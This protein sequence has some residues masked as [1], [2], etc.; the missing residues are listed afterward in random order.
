MSRELTKCNKMLIKKTKKTK[1][2]YTRHIPL[3]IQIDEETVEAEEAAVAGSRRT[4]PT[5]VQQVK[6]PA[7]VARPFPNATR[8]SSRG[9]PP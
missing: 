9:Y 3:Q 6:A 7:R 1:N 2:N 5:P 4:L 8:P